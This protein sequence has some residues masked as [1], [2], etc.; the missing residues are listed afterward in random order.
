MTF[1]LSKFYS[2]IFENTTCI[3]E[4]SLSE[5]PDFASSEDRFFNMIALDLLTTL[6]EIYKSGV[7]R[8]RHFLFNMDVAELNSF[9][10]AWN[11]LWNILHNEIEFGFLLSFTEF[12]Y[13]YNFS[14]DL[15]QQPFI[16]FKNK[17][18]TIETIQFCL[19]YQRNIHLYSMSRWVWNFKVIFFLEGFRLS[20]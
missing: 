7:Y 4:V 11:Y 18:K 6:V 1:F 3:R 10:L 5:V 8:L 13:I 15:K 16:V 19:N 20:K 2:A 9:I 17:R 14:T 12:D